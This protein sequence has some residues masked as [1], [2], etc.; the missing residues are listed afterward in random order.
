VLDVGDSLQDKLEVDVFNYGKGSGN[1]RYGRKQESW[2]RV[3]SRRKREG[4]RTGEWGKN[5]S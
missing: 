5:V 4:E 1:V 2:K 3:G